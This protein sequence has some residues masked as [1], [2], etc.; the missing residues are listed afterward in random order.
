MPE[1]HAAQLPCCAD[2]V[3]A[4]FEP[5]CA[6]LLRPGATV[7]TTEFPRFPH[8]I[9]LWANLYQPAGQPRGVRPAPCR[10]RAR[11]AA[12]NESASKSAW[13]EGSDSQ[14]PPAHGF[15]GLRTNCNGDSLFRSA[16]CAASRRARPCML[17]QSCFFVRLGKPE[18]GL[19]TCR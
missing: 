7:M 17:E 16:S 11:Q 3:T 1:D 4:G 14:I 9:H 5:G 6:A 8:R 18:R 2:R 10:V 19:R 12:G 15:R 13:L